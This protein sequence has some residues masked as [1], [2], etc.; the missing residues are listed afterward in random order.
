MQVVSPHQIWICNKPIV[1][2]LYHET[3]EN[4]TVVYTQV[5]VHTLANKRVE[6]KKVPI[7]IWIRKSV[8]EK[9]DLEYENRS[10]LIN[11]LLVLYFEEKEEKIKLDL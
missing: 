1:E 10:E 11:S 2:K 8:L 9:I 6:D 3:Q 5:G 4:A 7:K